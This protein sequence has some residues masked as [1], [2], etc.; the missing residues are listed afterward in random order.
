MDE[1]G[2]TPEMTEFFTR[3][4]GGEWHLYSSH[5]RVGS[6]ETENQQAKLDLLGD[7]M[8]LRPGARVL[9][10]GSGWGGPLT[11][12]ATRYG[13]SGV[14]ISLVPQQCEY[15]NRRAR[16]HGAALE[17][18]PCHWQDFVADEPF[19]AVMT[20]GVV[21]HFPNLLDYFV[22]ANQWLRP[23]GILLNEEM[24]LLSPDAQHES[25]VRANRAMAALDEVRKK[26][27]GIGGRLV[28]DEEGSYVT[29]DREL[30]L[31]RTAGFDIERV[32][33]LSMTDYQETVRGW[34]DNCE[35][36]RAELTALTSH[37]AYRWYRLYFRLFCRLIDDR[38]MRLDVV[39]ARRPDH[40]P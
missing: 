23:G 12:L 39:T 4:L 7:L 19:D 8:H 13:V 34:L 9:D 15:A 30:D 6:S 38:A 11:Y 31:L 14:G 40:S 24:H 3:V 28:I 33:A 37:D 17:F 25:V 27:R 16:K 21:V 2:N 32:V 35:R 20:T 29:L 10:I 5:I 22:R 26:G 18:R 1:S 36:Q